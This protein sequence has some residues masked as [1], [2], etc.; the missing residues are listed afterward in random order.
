VVHLGSVTSEYARTRKSK[1]RANPLDTFQVIYFKHVEDLGR[2]QHYGMKLWQTEQFVTFATGKGHNV[3]PAKR[4][5]RRVH[6]IPSLGGT[7]VRPCCPVDERA[8]RSLT[9]DSGQP[10]Q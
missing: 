9:P 5:A 6:V 3:A 1:S 10:G 8:M 7:P 4:S 2:T